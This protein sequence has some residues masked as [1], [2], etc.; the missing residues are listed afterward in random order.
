MIKGE[1]VLHQTMEN[2]KV[3]LMIHYQ[4]IEEISQIQPI[5]QEIEDIVRDNY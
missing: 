3:E 1:K 5:I 4:V 2:G